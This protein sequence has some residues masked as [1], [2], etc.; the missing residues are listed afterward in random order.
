MDNN[1]NKLTTIKLSGQLGKKF[2]KIHRFYISSP[3]EAIRALCSQVKG[4]ESHMRDPERKTLYK[5]F[6]NDSQIDPENELHIERDLHEVRIAPVIQGAKSGLFQAI[7]GV[8]LIAGA[9]FTG[10]M[11]LAGMTTGWAGTMFSMGLSLALGGIA[12]MLSPQPK[13][14][15]GKASSNTPNSGFSVENR[16]V[17]SGIPVPLVFGKCVVPSVTVSAGIF[18]SDT[19]G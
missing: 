6:A 8:A 4:F 3:G 14:D 16:N 1:K 5:V 17:T 7:L 10:G 18:A 13:L 12:Q 11:T 2:G 15:L 9:F 19:N